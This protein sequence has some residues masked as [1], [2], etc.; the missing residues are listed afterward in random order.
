M[1]FS[2]FLLF[3]AVALLFSG[4]AGYH[5]GPIPP[6]FMAGI[7]T[8]TVPTFKNDT[9][10]PRVEVALANAVIKQ[11]QQDGTYKIA[12]EKDADAIVQGTLTIIRR[13][14]AR[15]VTGNILATREFTLTITCQFSVTNRAT[16]ELID[17]R[18][19]TGQTSFF[20]SGSDTIAADVNQDE[21]QAIPLAAED[22]AVQLVSQYSEGW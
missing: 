9:L 5:I 12:N 17:R 10:E 22:M 1:R 6:K 13:S 18:S 14:P 15:S 11:F 16:G 7:H 3:A 4:C 20:V 2:S 8:L 21:R 19:V